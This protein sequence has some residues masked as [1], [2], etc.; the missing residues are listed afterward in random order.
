M[1][2]DGCGLSSNI[3]PQLLNQLKEFILEIYN[4]GFH[5]GLSYSETLE[6]RHD[7]PYGNN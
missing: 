2:E 6:N 1:I 7:N 4:D 5:K 3:D